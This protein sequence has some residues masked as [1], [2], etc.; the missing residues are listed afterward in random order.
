ME[1]SSRFFML[2]GAS[3]ALLSASI[4]IGSGS[5]T[6]RVPA[7]SAAAAC[8]Q[9]GTVNGIKVPTSKQSPTVARIC[10]NGVLKAALAP[11][12][13]FG[14]QDQTGKFRGPGAEIVG[15]EMARDLHV[16]FSIV[17]T[18]WD[19]IVAGLQANHYELIIAGLTYTAVRAKLID[20]V[21]YHSEGTCYAVKKSSAIKTLN[22]L[23]ASS[24]TIGVYTGTS[25]ET[26]I[27][28]RYPSA[29]IDAAVEGTGGGYRLIDV[30]AGRIDAAPI[31]N[32]AAFA[33]EKS[34]PD[35]RV[36][37]AP[38]QCLS[39][40]DIAGQLGFGLPK[41]KAFQ[42]FIA[43]IVKKDKPAMEKLVRKYTAPKYIPVGH[44]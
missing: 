21:L 28:K 8:G 2:I 35:L 31:D 39:H 23:N 29:K 44:P 26:D 15:P 33:V 30:M 42:K 13:P 24:V 12:A 37:P 36:I 22:D 3:I 10:K 18:G 5:W 6:G 16:N 7:V 20:Y 40:P 27:P 4:S 14:F 19:T 32:V 34:W 38:K 25:W 41:D 1:R 17:P 43:A 11:F 9:G